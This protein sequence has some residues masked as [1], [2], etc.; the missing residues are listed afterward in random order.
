MPIHPRRELREF[1]SILNH[2]SRF[3]LLPSSSD[4][5]GKG[6][7]LAI[8]SHILEK[9]GTVLSV[10]CVIWLFCNVREGGQGAE[11]VLSPIQPQAASPQGL[12]A[13]P[14]QH[15]AVLQKKLQVVV[16]QSAQ[17]MVEQQEEGAH[18]R[19]P[20]ARPMPTFSSMGAS[21]KPYPPPAGRPPA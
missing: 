16:R 2:K 5:S 11:L 6:L 7:R 4:K 13:A 10:F 12:Q 1:R 17:H 20:P 14:L 19:T 18:T 15:Q 9:L 3:R 21:S 8:L